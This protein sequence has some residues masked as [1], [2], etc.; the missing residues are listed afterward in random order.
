[1]S[2]VFVLFQVNTPHLHCSF[3]K[4]VSEIPSCIRIFCHIRA[5]SWCFSA[6]VCDLLMSLLC[7]QHNCDAGKRDSTA[8]WLLIFNSRILTLHFFSAQNIEGSNDSQRLRMFDWLF[9]WRALLVTP[10]LWENCAVRL[11]VRF[12]V[13][14]KSFVQS[15]W[16]VLW[17]RSLVLT[18]HIISVPLMKSDIVQCYQYMG[19][20]HQ[21]LYH[22]IM[23]PSW[24]VL[25]A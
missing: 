15:L 22:V 24:H 12:A 8:S 2:S 3:T 9:T 11:F 7:F 5:C 25:T 23:C 20:Q 21:L 4:A 16:F 18:V 17:V 19:Y 14:F 1:M 6:C 13:F 10:L